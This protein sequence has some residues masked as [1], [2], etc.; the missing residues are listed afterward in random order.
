MCRELK[1]LLRGW[2]VLHSSAMDVEPGPLELPTPELPG[3]CGQI[4][5][6]ARELHG[7]PRRS[8]DPDEVLSAVTRAAISL[9]PGVDHAGVT[10][11]RGNPRADRVVALSS[12]AATGPVPETVDRLQ[13]EHGQG[14]CFDAIRHSHTVVVGDYSS[15]ERW[16]AFLAAVRTQTP[17]RSSLAIELYTTDR[18]LGALNLYAD[19]V[20]AFN[21]EAIVSASVFGT[22]A[23]I[24]LS[25][26]R[27]DEQF[28]SAL[29]SRDVIGQAKGV[30]MERYNIDAVEA[31][32]LLSKLSQDS[33]IAL[34]RVAAQLIEADHPTTPR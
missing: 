15:D 17:V 8:P 2:A 30:I 25:G 29:A 11:V 9:I 19:T 20:D 5:G 13:H 34:A 24:A 14:P 28:R 26:A 32:E 27:R 1:G 3:L 23:A 31:F 10:L 33:N 6:L 7:G 4:A 21:A 22:H 12:T 16:P 18:E